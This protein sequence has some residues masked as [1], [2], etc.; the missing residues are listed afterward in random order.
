MNKSK[1]REI[2]PDTKVGALLDDFPELEPVLM[3]LS[4]K[5]EKLKN[6]VLRRTVAKVATLRQ[7]AKVGGVPLPRLINE[8]RRAAGM[9][10]MEVEESVTGETSPPPWFAPETV[11]ETLDIRPFIDSGEQPISI[12]MEKLAAL[13]P[14]KILK[15]I[16]PFEPVPLLDLAKQKGFAVHLRK[17]AEAGSVACFFRKPD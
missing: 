5:F 16:A 9:D 6:P 13:K 15:V 8:L 7:V 4:P 3:E 10:Q 2:T 1:A 14:G 17:E 12:A 11:Y